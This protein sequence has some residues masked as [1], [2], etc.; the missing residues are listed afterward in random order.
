MKNLEATVF[1]INCYNLCMKN[2][3]INSHQMTVRWHG[4]D[5]NM[6]CKVPL[7]ISFKTYGKVAVNQGKIHD[8][9]A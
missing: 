2:S 4:N 3:G 5:L 8:T 9:W 6:S 1:Q 7:E